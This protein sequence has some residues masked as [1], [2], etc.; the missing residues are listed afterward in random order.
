MSENP[1]PN[2]YGQPYPQQPYYRAPDHEQAATVLV[3]GILGIVLCQVISPIAWVMG[4]R[5]VREIDASG[6][7][8][9]GR[10]AANAGRICG[11]VGTAII[12]VGVLFLLLLAV[13]F[14]VGLAAA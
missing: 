5:V 6:G 2:P 13:L 7:A 11:I 14:L 8:I 12:G 4:N 9:G 1:P 3:L 10:G